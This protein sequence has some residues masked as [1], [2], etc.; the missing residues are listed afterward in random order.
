MI[1]FTDGFKKSRR[2]EFSSKLLVPLL[3][4]GTFLVRM[5]LWSCVKLHPPAWPSMH[6][7]LKINLKKEKMKWLIQILLIQMERGKNEIFI[8]Q[9]KNNNNNGNSICYVFSEFSLILIHHVL[10]LSCFMINFFWKWPKKWLI[11]KL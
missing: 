4:I 5:I 9:K 3:I 11:L 1:K 10:V 7:D 2:R 6:L 8:S